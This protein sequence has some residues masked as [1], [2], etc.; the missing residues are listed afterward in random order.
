MESI[1]YDIQIYQRLTDSGLGAGEAAV[2]RHQ[3]SVVALAGQNLQHLRHLLTPALFSP[4]VHSKPD[5]C[6][7][8]GELPPGRKTGAR[9]SV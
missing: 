9:Q 1:F 4:S 5:V 7:V 8:T 6:S 2:F 3:V